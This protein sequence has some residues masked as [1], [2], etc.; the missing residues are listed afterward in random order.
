[1]RPWWRHRSTALG[2]VEDEGH[3]L[4]AE[5]SIE[6][7][8]DVAAMK[9]MRAAIVE[10]ESVNGIDAEKFEFAGLDEVGDGVDEALVLEL[11]LVAGAGGEADERR[12]PVTV[13]DDAHVQAEARGLPAMVFAL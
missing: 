1:M 3:D 10:A 4:L 5:V 11:P 8:L 12:A 6:Y 2:N 7:G 9:G 13:D